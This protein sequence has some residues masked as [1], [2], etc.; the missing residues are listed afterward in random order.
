MRRRPGIHCRGPV[1][2]Q[3]ALAHRGPRWHRRC[4]RRIRAAVPDRAESLRGLLQVRRPSH[5]TSAALR[6]WLASL[7]LLRHRSL[8]SPS[9]SP[10]SAEGSI[11]GRSR[12]R[13]ASDPR[14]PQRGLAKRAMPPFLQRASRSLPSPDFPH[15]KY[16]IRGRFN[17]DP[18]TPRCCF[19]ER[20]TSQPGPLFKLGRNSRCWTSLSLEQSSSP[21]PPE[22]AHRALLSG[23]ARCSCRPVRVNGCRARHLLTRWSR[24][25]HGRTC[26]AWCPAIP[27]GA[28]PANWDRPLSERLDAHISGEGTAPPCPP[29]TPRQARLLALWRC[30][31]QV[32]RH[33]TA[34]Y[35][36]RHGP[37]RPG[38]GGAHRIAGRARP[39]RKD[40]IDGGTA[41]RGA[42]KVAPIR[43]LHSLRSVQRGVSSAHAFP[44]V[45]DDAHGL[46]DSS[47]S[48]SRSPS[49]GLWLGQ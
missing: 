8:P 37:C 2:L 43:R 42:Y 29:G 22:A 35:W 6:L 31:G 4:H 47:S 46:C 1:R 13:P 20:R 33:P 28:H 11:A 32:R 14:P 30:A 48:S 27:P 26:L 34:A 24:E 16:P 45:H 17:H 38:A 21:S 3:S 39:E 41:F 12:T 49:H 10:R 5:S 7:L 23:S 9:R 15:R 18:C 44:E 40:P 19:V 25:R 36:P